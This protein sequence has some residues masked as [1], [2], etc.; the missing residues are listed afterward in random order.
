MIDELFVQLLSKLPEDI[1]NHIY[2]YN[3]THREAMASVLKELV[4][5]AEQVECETCGDLH[6]ANSSIRMGKYLNK[7]S[8]IGRLYYCC[9]EC[10]MVDEYLYS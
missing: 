9:E 6:Y 4:E 8:R 7:T 10:L 1:L 5:V 3:S 2:E